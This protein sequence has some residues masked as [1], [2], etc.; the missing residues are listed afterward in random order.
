MREELARLKERYNGD[1][2]EYRATVFDHPNA[3]NV[4][5]VHNRGGHTTKQ[6]EKADGGFVVS[7]PQD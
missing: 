5:R 4:K 3:S 2:E 7:I 1:R 6:G